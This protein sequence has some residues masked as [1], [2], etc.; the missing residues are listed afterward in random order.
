VGARRPELVPRI[1]RLG[2]RT[3]SAYTILCSIIFAVGGRIIASGFT[4]DAAL[5]ATAV[6]LL[7][8]AAVFQA[9]DGANIVARAILRGVGDVRFAAVVGVVTAW[10]MTPPL[11]WLLGYRAGLGAFGGWLGLCGET[12]IGAFIL[13]HRLNS[14]H[15][16]TI[17]EATRAA[18]TGV[19][20]DPEG[21]A[22][23]TS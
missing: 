9:F 5:A 7:Y 3:A 17:A 16:R 2:L 1:A 23:A 4:S 12:I 10:V 14:G 20:G 8:V 19:D 15:W 22:A 21:D 18:A 6:R 11:A 13:W